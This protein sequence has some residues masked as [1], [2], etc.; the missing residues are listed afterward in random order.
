M[1]CMVTVIFISNSGT[2]SPIA[3]D[4]GDEKTERSW[5]SFRESWMFHAQLLLLVWLVF[6]PPPDFLIPGL[7]TWLYCSATSLQTSEQAVA[8]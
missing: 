3:A 7:E 2:S 6:V 8:F 4:V 1:Q 5:L